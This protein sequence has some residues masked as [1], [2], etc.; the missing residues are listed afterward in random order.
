MEKSKEPQTLMGNQLVCWMIGETQSIIKDIWKILAENTP[1]LIKN[2]NLHI[3][4]VHEFK[5]G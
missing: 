4:K 3:S 2:N 5:V 1:D